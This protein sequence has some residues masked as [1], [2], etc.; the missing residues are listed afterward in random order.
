[1]SSRDP[2]YI[3]KVGGRTRGKQAR[4]GTRDEAAAPAGPVSTF[5]LSANVAVPALQ[6]VVSRGLLRSL[7]RMV[8][9]HHSRCNASALGRE[10]SAAQE[11][12]LLVWRHPFL[13][14]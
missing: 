8:V 2:R 13:F 5:V 3:N 10:Q 1:M 12:L 11:W 9:L 7:H 6:V 4:R 14:Q